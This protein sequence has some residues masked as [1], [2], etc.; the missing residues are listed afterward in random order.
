MGCLRSSAARARRRLRQRERGDSLPRYHARNPL[1][2][3]FG[4]PSLKD[5][6]AAEPLQGKRGLGLAVDLGDGL[7]E[8]AEVHILLLL[9]AQAEPGHADSLVDQLLGPTHCPPQDNA[10]VTL[11]NN[12][13]ELDRPRE[14]SLAAILGMPPNPFRS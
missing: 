14:A 7:A 3:Q 12:T 11:V 6:V 13:Q 5:R 9:I 4:G 8:Q 2:H 1:P 10:Y